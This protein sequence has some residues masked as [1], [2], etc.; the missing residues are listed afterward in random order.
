MKDR[1]EIW[2]TGYTRL[3]GFFLGV[4]TGVIIGVIIMMFLV[5][6]LGVA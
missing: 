4:L 3:R 2:L 5:W 6:S 1:F